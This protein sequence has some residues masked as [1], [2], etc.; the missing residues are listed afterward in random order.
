MLTW[1]I[2]FYILRFYKDGVLMIEGY[3]IVVVVD[4]SLF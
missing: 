2:C 4:E 1:N 3:A